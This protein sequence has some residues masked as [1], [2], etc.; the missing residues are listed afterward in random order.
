VPKFASPRI[1]IASLMQET[2]TFSPIPTTRAVF[3]TYYVL[4]GDE[5]LDGYGAARVEVP[6]FLDVLRAAGASPVPLFAAYAAAAGRCT[7][8]TFEEFMEEIETRLA[9][10]GPLDGL[11]L[12]LHG[13][14]VLEDAPDGEGEII[15]RLR[16]ILPADRPIGVSLDLHGHVTPR[17]L[18]P[19]TFL[20]GYRDYPHTDI[21]ETGERTARLMLDVVAGRRW[22]VMA[23][24][25]RPVLVSPVC[26]R[27]TDGPLKPV[28]DAARQMEADGTVLHA[29]IFPVQPWLDVPDLGFAALVCA[30][31]DPR[32]ARNAAEGLAEE[33]WR[34]RADFDPGLVSLAQAIAVGLSA[35]GVTVV[36]DTGDAPTGGAAAD[37]AA[38]LAGLLA[39]GAANAARL[40]LATL[41]DPAAAAAAHRAGLEATLS[42]TLG[43]AFSP[44]T[45][46][47]VVARVI[48]LSDGS[49]VMR[50]KGTEGLSIRMGPTAVLAIG[51]IRMLVRSNPSTEWDTG[52]YL[53][54]GLDPRQAALVFVKS[55]S[56]FRASFGPL[57]ARILL[58]DTPGST[59][60]DMR[61]IPFRHVTRP[62]YPLDG[63]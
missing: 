47:A 9:A 14:L 57:A 45:P 43:H 10:S 24:A 35:P 60:A 58:A 40:S 50:D 4:R 34:R 37:S 15:E 8:A 30:D 11:L 63:M 18:Q 23:L 62:L 54:Q 61:R 36:S 59:C 55:P 48:S 38:V 7:R 51:S 19:N 42:L 20:I 13:A 27:T 56:H 53:S 22:P 2:N 3:E 16:A 5:L 31:G 6:A 46:V 21:Y 25:K 41:C 33:L 39:A 44:G 17:M 12:A 49:Y 29:A 52:M 32:A 28:A 26:A 1:A